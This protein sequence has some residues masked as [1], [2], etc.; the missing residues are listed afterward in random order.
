MVVSKLLILSE[1]P[2]FYCFLYFRTFPIIDLDYHY[3]GND[4]PWILHFTMCVFVCAHA[5][6][7]VI[8]VQLLVMVYSLHSQS[9]LQIYQLFF[10]PLDLLSRSPLQTV[11]QLNWELSRELKCRVKI[12][13]CNTTSGGVRNPYAAWEKETTLQTFR[14]TPE[15]QKNNQEFNNYS[16]IMCFFFH[17]SEKKSSA[18]TFYCF[19]YRT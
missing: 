14:Q 6:G 11:L 18:L 2:F 13:E 3:D 7:C 19:F 15:R 5:P 1:N 16:N 9:I 12:N 4:G 17:F 10:P 8:L